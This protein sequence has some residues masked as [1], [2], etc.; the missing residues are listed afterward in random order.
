LPGTT[1]DEAV[2]ALFIEEMALARC[3]AAAGAPKLISILLLSI[4]MAIQ[5]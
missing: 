5:L 3:H 2:V 4:Q 1:D